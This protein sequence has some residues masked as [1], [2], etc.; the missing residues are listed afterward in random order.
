MG[1]VSAAY[2]AGAL[3]LEDA[4]CVSFHR[5][6]VQ[7]RAAGLGKMLATDLTEE[8]ASRYLE[9]YHGRVT[10][11]AINSPL[12]L[13]LSGDAEPLEEISGT[14]TRAGRFNRFLQVE[15]PYHSHHMDP[16]QDDLL[17]S[18]A[19]LSPRIPS[20]PLYSTVSGGP[21]E[22]ALP[23]ARYWWR[24]IREPVRL[25]VALV[26]MIE[27]GSRISSWKWVPIPFFPFR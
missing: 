22:T 12:S 14:L 5:S 11:A 9:P 21:V 17:E 3:T 19:G 26:G 27:G 10:I 23:D 6:R 15:V 4:V 13:T 24:N 16:L 25:K 7:A 2:S 1:E 20:T 18:L 8:E